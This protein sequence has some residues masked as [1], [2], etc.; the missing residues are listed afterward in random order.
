MVSLI[1][2][3]I[4]NLGLLIIGSINILLGLGYFYLNSLM[5]GFFPNIIGWFFI[6]VG[7]L[8]LAWLFW[9]K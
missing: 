2:G 5:R 1:M 9:G 4:D 3:K 8:F 6:G 7:A